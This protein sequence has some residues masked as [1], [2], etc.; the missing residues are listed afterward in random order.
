MDD[1]IFHNLRMSMA[2]NNGQTMLS[3]A[4][5]SGHVGFEIAIPL[6]RNDALVIEA[7]FGTCRVSS[8]CPPPTF[9]A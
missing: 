7:D 9:P 8:G 3:L 1:V 5:E 4:V 6:T 2:T